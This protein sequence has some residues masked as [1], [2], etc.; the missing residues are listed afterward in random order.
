MT[1]IVSLCVI[2]IVSRH[3]VTYEYPLDFEGFPPRHTARES[4]SLR[5]APP[6]RDDDREGARRLSRV[7]I[8]MGML[9][10]FDQV[11]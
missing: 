3:R 9:D 11:A 7:S 8:L 1:V 5:R 10:L 6:A 2:V 4:T